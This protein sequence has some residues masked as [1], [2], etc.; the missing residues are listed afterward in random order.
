MGAECES[1]Y[2]ARLAATVPLIPNIPENA[3]NAEAMAIICQ[4]FNE[5]RPIQ[6][7]FKHARSLLTAR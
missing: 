2:R 4:A 6:R 1:L 7:S 3:T 5:P